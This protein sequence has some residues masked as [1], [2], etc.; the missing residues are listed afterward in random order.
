MKTIRLS[1]ML[2]I[3]TLFGM[4]AA[5]AMRPNERVSR[6]VRSELLRLPQYGVFDY[7]EFRLSG[8]VVILEGSVTQPALKASAETGGGERHRRFTRR[9][10]DR[11]TAEIGER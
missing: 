7:L 1:A 11:S 4:F 5:G 9:Q 8:G 2:G 10:P 6:E 3:L